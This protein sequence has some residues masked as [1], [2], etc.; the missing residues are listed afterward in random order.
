MSGEAQGDATG[1]SSQPTFAERVASL[2]DDEEELRLRLKQLRAARPLLER[3][4]A[5]VSNAASENV[6]TAA[7]ALQGDLSVEEIKALRDRVDFTNQVQTGLTAGLQ[8]FGEE[9]SRVREAIGIL[10]NERLTVE[11]AKAAKAAARATWAAVVVSA[12]AIATTLVL[13]MSGLA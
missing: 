5:Q 3:L 2:G 10:T 1:G 4:S 13:A 7:S 9:E 8:A 11:T 12:L 6:G